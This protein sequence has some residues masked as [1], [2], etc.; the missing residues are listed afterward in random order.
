MKIQPKILE[1]NHAILAVV[2][3]FLLGLI[4]YSNTFGNSFQF[5][6]WT[7]ILDNPNITTLGRLPDLFQYLPTRFVGFLSFALNY[8]IGRFGVHW[9]HLVNILIHILTAVLVFWFTSL[10]FS[11]PAMKKEGISR[12]KESISFLVAAIFLTHPLQTEAVD[13]IF[14]R[15]T[16]FAAFFYMLALSFYARAILA[17]E[18]GKRIDKFCYASSVGAAFIG[19]FTKENAATLPAMVVLYDFYFLR[20]KKALHWKY[21]VPFLLLLPVVPVTLLLS[22][23]IAFADLGRLLANP[24]HN[25]ACYLWTQF[26]VLVTYLRLFLIPVGQNLDYDYPLAHTFWALPVLTSLCILV[27]ILIIGVR[28]FSRYRL[29]SFSIFWFFVAL[30]PESSIIPLSD[31]IFEHRLYLPLVGCSVF[32]V[33]TVYYIIGKR[34]IAAMA[35]IVMMT[36]NWYAL[37]TYTRNFDWQTALTL[38]N[39]T[40]YKSPEKARPNFNRGCAY[41]FANNH[42]KAVVDFNKAFMLNNQRIDGDQDYTAAYHK[43]L[44]SGDRYADVYNFFG[45]KYAEIGMFDQA[46]V[47][48]KIAVT[49]DPSH[50][51]YYSNLCAAFGAAKKFK[52]AISVGKRILQL[53]P[54][55]S[56]GHYSL[57]VAYYFDKR[58]DLARAHLARATELGFTPDPDFVA[59]V[60]K[61]P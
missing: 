5:D 58:P 31:P 14:Q 49:A 24:V 20:K 59:N 50:I 53:N 42:K 34:S 11:T 32:A 41:F 33:C 36:V 3:L 29:M 56:A 18:N 10:T 8:Q 12:Y 6:D 35:I 25:S 37:L 27:S 44:L 52:E 55:S 4:A 46:I 38:W 60:M 15:V 61:S 47:L 26:Q 16:L 13:Y 9:Y 1:L 2:A 51:P 40:V 19:M 22:K 54:D 39:D 57:S 43:L 7:F 23:P 45:I 17:L 30:L 21:D 28:L 48:F